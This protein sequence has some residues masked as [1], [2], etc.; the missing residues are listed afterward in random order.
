MEY[1]EME[2]ELRE[3]MRLI[4]IGD[5]D[6]MLEASSRMR[7]LYADNDITDDIERPFLESD[8]GT[9]FHRLMGF[10]IFE[11]PT[12]EQLKEARNRLGMSRNEIRLEMEGITRSV[13]EAKNEEDYANASVRMKKLY[14]EN[15]VPDEVEA[16]F[17]DAGAPELFREAMGHSILSN[18]P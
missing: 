9:K 18:N 6:A 16:L 1:G 3:I 2:R 15:N 11:E 5:Y 14:A 10:G 17:V 8:L 7:R 13:I 4:G 12:G